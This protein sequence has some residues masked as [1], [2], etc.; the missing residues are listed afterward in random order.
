MVTL[1]NI[2]NAEFKESEKWAEELDK[3]AEN[4]NYQKPPLFGVPVS[5]KENIKV[6]L[7][8][9]SLFLKNN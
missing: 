7:F 8:Y 1:S 5:I 6:S 9:I 3:K 4:K 2:M